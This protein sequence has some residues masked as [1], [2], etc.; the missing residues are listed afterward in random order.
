MVYRFYTD[1]YLSHS[2]GPWKKHKYKAKI[3]NKYIYDKSSY[4]KTGEAIGRRVR[5]FL[6][7]MR[8]KVAQFHSA[9]KQLVNG[10]LTGLS[11]K[12]VDSIAGPSSANI[13]QEHANQKR[14][15]NIQDKP[16]TA[17]TAGDV[18]AKG[19]RNTAPQQPHSY[20][21]SFSSSSGGKHFGKPANSTKKTTTGPSS[22]NI[23]QQHAAQKQNQYSYNVSKKPNSQVKI[24][25]K[26]R[27]YFARYNNN[28]TSSTGRHFEKTVKHPDWRPL[29]QKQQ[30]I[31]NRQTEE[32][33][34]KDSY[35]YSRDGLQEQFNNALQKV[36]KKKKKR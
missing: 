12:T 13:S 9:G 30:E 16:T 36:K 27:E 7:R 28:N 2:S 34:K 15:E 17:K 19:V 35:T 31:L 3:G 24:A 20:H 10:F 21:N 5:S 14:Q 29:T 8:A 11:G 1:S 25:E 26:R 4:A 18:I 23:S 33:R 22:S 32:K 6:K